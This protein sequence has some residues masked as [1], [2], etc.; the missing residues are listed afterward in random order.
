MLFPLLLPWKRLNVHLKVDHHLETE[1]NEEKREAAS[2]ERI[3]LHLKSSYRT[4]NV[5]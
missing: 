1:A 5:N 2:S 3:S 4:G